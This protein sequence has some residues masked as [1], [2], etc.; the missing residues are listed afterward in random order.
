MGWDGLLDR[1]E[2]LNC[3]EV[4]LENLGAYLGRKRR[5]SP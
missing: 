2:N 3:R 1:T 5:L 4:R